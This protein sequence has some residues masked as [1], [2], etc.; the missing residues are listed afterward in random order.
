MQGVGKFEMMRTA[1]MTAMTA[2]GTPITRTR[3]HGLR[4]PGSRP[5][6]RRARIAPVLCPA[7]L[8]RQL[9]GLRLLDLLASALRHGAP[10]EP[11]PLNLSMEG[12]APLTRA[13]PVVNQKFDAPFCSM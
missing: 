2:T 4:L 3:R 9:L 5:A 8:G 10:R 12:G 11:P 7:V 13:F 6:F 1:A